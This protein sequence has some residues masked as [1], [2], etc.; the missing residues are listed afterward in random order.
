M[1]QVVVTARIDSET[2]AKLDRIGIEY[3]RKR[4]W[5]IARAIERYAGE[6]AAHL[7]FLQEGEDAIAR[8]E[9]RTHEEVMA[10]FSDLPDRRK[11]AA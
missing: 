2:A 9:V 1:P 8:G 3:D 7:D 6:G 11:S 4:A 10:E 5:L